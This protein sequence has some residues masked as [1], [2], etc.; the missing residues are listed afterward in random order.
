MIHR[1]DEYVKASRTIRRLTGLRYIYNS[2][3]G[4][5]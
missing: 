3:K 5:R 1:L 4:K 2:R